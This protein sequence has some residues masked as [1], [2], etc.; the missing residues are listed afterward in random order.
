[1]RQRRVR[2]GCGLASSSGVAVMLSVLSQFYS[3]EK[4]AAHFSGTTC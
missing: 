4:A 3:R 2:R 1:M